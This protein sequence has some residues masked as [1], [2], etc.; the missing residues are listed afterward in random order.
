MV[1]PILLDRA[2][3]AAIAGRRSGRLSSARGTGRVVDAP[4]ELNFERLE[5]I[6]SRH[7]GFESPGLLKTDTDGFDCSIVEG[8]LDLLTRLRP[9]LFL[10]YDPAFL[11]PAFDAVPFFSQLAEA[12]YDQILYWENIGDFAGALWCTD[13]SAVR[14]FHSKYVG[15][16]NLR[17]ADVA[18]FHKED[19]ALAVAFAARERDPAPSHSMAASRR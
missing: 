1:G 15:F 9:V 7:P 12:G 11:A 6:L 19:E 4:D 8:H 5:T 10:E 14:A 2:L 18:I 3:V 17:Y 13:E 16:N